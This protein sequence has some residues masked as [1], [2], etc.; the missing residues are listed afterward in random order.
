MTHGQCTIRT[1]F[2]ALVAST[3]WSSVHSLPYPA[4]SVVER[5][6]LTTAHDSF[7]G[8]AK[9]FEAAA[10][11]T[12]ERLRASHTRARAPHLVCTEYSRGGETISQL[13]QFLSPQSVRPVAHSS[14][15]GACFF[16]TASDAE[17]R[18]L[19]DDPQFGLLSISPFP[20]ALK[21]APG[22]LEHGDSR[23][24]ASQSS[25]GLTTTHGHLLQKGNVEGLNVELSP[26]TLPAHSP[27]AGA[28]IAQLLNDLNSESIDL[29]SSNVW[30][31]P[32]VGNWE[33]LT[34]PGGALRE[35]EWSMAATL[36]NELSVSGRTTAG[37]ICSWDSISMHHA[38]DDLLLVSG[39]DHL[40][41]P[42]SQDV[43]GSEETTELRI[44]CFM[45]L[46]SFL[47]GR[48]EVLRVAPRR[49]KHLKNAV[50]RALIQ[51]ATITSTPLTAAG[52]D[53]TGQVIQV[54]DT[55]LDETS[56]F[57]IDDDGEEVPH[58][59]Y[60]EDFGFPVSPATSSPTPS[61]ASTSFSQTSTPT[62]SVILPPSATTPPTIAAYSVL[63]GDFSSY[64]NR[65]KVIQYIDL[66]K[67][68]SNPEPTTV[69]T[70][71][72]GESF[73]F[74]SSG[75]F[76]GDVVEG[77]GTHVSGSAAGATLN[78]P[79]ETV[80]CDG[81]KVPG[82]V[83]GCINGATS[84]WGDDLL[85]MSYNGGPY[86][87]DVDRICPM[88]GCD[89][90]TATWCLNDD[91]EQTLTEHGG[92]AQGAKLAFFDVVALAG[93]QVVPLMGY[94]GNGL[95]ESCL[96]AGCK[97]HSNSWGEDDNP[98]CI[99][100]AL[101]VGYDDFMYKNPENLLIF[102][103]GNEGATVDG[104]PCTANSPSIA[105]NI[106]AVGAT[107]TGETRLSTTGPDGGF[108]DVDTVADFSSYGPTRDNR[109]KPEIVAPGDAI[110]S[111]R[112]DGADNISCRLAAFSGTSMSCPIVA[113][114]AAMVRQYFVDANF[115]LADVTARG[116]CNDGGPQCQAFSPSSATVKALLINSANLMGGSSEPD[117]YRGFGRIHL[118][119]G[120]PLDGEGDLAIFV[121]DSAFLPKLSS[122]EFFFD[123]DAAAGL[124]FR[125]TLSWID[126]PATSS[127]VIQLVHDL[128]LVVESPSGTMHTMWATGVAD[129]LN[130]NE[131]V[132][133]AAAD[134]ESG[135]WIV[136]VSTKGLLGESQN[137][138]LVV[139]GAIV[140][141][142]SEPFYS[143]LYSAAP[144]AAPTSSPSGAGSDADPSS[145]GSIASTPTS[146][147]ILLAGGVLSAIAAAA[148]A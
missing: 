136:R 31:D 5:S 28:F 75:G 115:Y 60:Y 56:C 96:E 102:A 32:G 79:V 23:D 104:R 108:A 128:D 123:V 101:D 33:H 14:E 17:A 124:D 54:L 105:K 21:V 114:A 76:Q 40:L 62:E 30:S 9:G 119:M 11:W 45:G 68:G 63:G 24:H 77:H 16:V 66:I 10:Q 61:P 141:S 55:G 132:I 113:G 22:V 26:G 49:S 109:I 91:V 51:S 84:T 111:A 78:S 12:G 143:S 116:W 120:M 43:R 64:P 80:V 145:S 37:D 103:V 93:T 137:Y 125:A 18:A 1:V 47:S 95:W 117:G 88:L 2:L 65:R 87:A 99:L 46:V 59:Y 106:L 13:Q 36:V 8:H 7:N 138:S 19:S 29:H 39:L 71:T 97:V 142:P 90:A 133:I 34:T 3:P 130:V 148:M 38:A 6:L 81:T 98:D 27:Q 127:S 72:D 82:C 122:Q 135:T 67:T 126:P 89:D 25:G 94:P 15:N 139:N 121:A 52:L 85:T 20:S 112:S 35:R 48:I 118:E 42:G 131:R 50:G 107:S 70:A 110:Y 144:T 100:D 83:G 58:G 146:L 69:S 4:L 129:S 147:V 53:G 57:F 134:V 140:F 92:M 74:F 86:D 44:A 41:Y 73:Y